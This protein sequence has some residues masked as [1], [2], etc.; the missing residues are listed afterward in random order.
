MDRRERCYKEWPVLREAFLRNRQFRQSCDT[1]GEL[2]LFSMVSQFFGSLRTVKDLIASRKRELA[3]IQSIYEEEIETLERK[4][5]SAR[6]SIEDWIINNDDGPCPCDPIK[7]EQFRAEKK[8]WFSK[9][10]LPGGG[11]VDPPAPCDNLSGDSNNSKPDNVCEMDCG[12]ENDSENIPEEPEIYCQS[13][14]FCL[15]TGSEFC[16]RCGRPVA[17]ESSP[18]D[19]YNVEVSCELGG[20]IDKPAS[21][22]SYVENEYTENVDR[23]DPYNETIDCS[24]ESNETE[25]ELGDPYDGTMDCS[26]KKNTG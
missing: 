23:G 3:C 22:S 16:S 8:E 6:V 25:S 14:G 5:L 11:H 26:S 15:H 17:V 19:G 12:S 20:N 4:L 13:C 9:W 7:L 24:F 2:D 1:G 18:S 21:P 10:F